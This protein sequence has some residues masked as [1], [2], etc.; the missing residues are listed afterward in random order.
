MARVAEEAEMTDLPDNSVPRST[1]EIEV[2]AL[3]KI[4]L[5]K[6]ARVEVYSAHVYPD[7]EYGRGK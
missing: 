2:S 4:L 3:L 6:G 1:D 7:T 5:D